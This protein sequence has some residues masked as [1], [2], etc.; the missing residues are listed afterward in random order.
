MI[1]RR[2]DGDA[3]GEENFLI[4]DVMERTFTI[5]RRLVS[6]L[7]GSIIGCS[8]FFYLRKVPVATISCS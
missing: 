4:G 3:K 5:M 6:H 8:G 1:L 7:N 2:R